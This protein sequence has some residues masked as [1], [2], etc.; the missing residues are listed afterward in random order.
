ML[1]LE[2]NCNFSCYD[3]MLRD[4]NFWPLPICNILAVQ[5]AQEMKHDYGKSI[6]ALWSNLQVG[7]LSA[8]EKQLYEIKK[9][10]QKSFH[11]IF[12]ISPSLFFCLFV[13]LLFAFLF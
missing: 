7:Y 10:S 3:N 2:V 1:F 4:T 12:I 8:T 6:P 13:P 11:S 9:I 5:P